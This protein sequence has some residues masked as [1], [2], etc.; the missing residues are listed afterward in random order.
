MTERDKPLRRV[1]LRDLMTRRIPPQTYAVD[2]LIPRGEV[3]LLA[4]RGGAGKSMVSLS[5]AL[6]AAAGRAWAGRHCAPQNV[7]LVTFEDPEER[8]C[9]RLQNIIRACGLPPECLDAIELWDATEDDVP[10]MV[11]AAVEG[12]RCAIETP[13]MQ[14]LREIALWAEGGLLVLDNGSDAFRGNRIDTDQ[15]RTFVRALAR[16]ARKHRIAVLLLV[17]PSKLAAQTGGDQMASGSAAWDNSCRSRLSMVANRDGTVAIAH[18][19]VNFGAQSGPIIL[20]RADHGVL[21][22]VDASDPAYAEAGA[23]DDAMVEAAMVAAIK[24]STT[25]P[26]ARSGPCTTWH[27]LST[28]DALGELRD[29]ACKGRFWS[30]VDRM[31]GTGRLAVEPYTTD[32]RKQRQRLRLAPMIGARE[33]A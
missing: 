2:G 3:T 15:V 33:A 12:V 16:L 25:V 27:A 23:A 32:Q 1:D 31:L 28:F 5:L 21:I 11:E 8:V 9:E 19:K 10:L 26:Y 17:H 4:G 7:L 13:A 22:P 24:T 14:H 20:R 30:S 6:H 29:K 18:G